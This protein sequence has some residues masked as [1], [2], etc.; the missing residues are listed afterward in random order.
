MTEAYNSPD[1]CMKGNSLRRLRET[2]GMS[3]PVLAQRMYQW[4]WYAKKVKRYEDLDH[5][6]LASNEMQDLL[7][8]LKKT[9]DQTILSSS[10]L[11]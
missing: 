8:I 9:S 4:G 6:T 10:A 2:L 7:K 11:P 1:K 3:R 5:F